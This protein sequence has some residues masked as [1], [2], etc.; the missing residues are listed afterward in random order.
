MNLSQMTGGGSDSYIGEIVTGNPNV[1]G[2]NP[3]IGTK[4]YLQTGML[5]RITGN[6]QFGAVIE[7]QPLLCFKDSYNNNQAWDYNNW[8]LSRSQTRHSSFG[9]FSIGYPKVVRHPNGNYFFWMYMYCGHMYPE[10]GYGDEGRYGTF[11]KW[12]SS[13][14]SGIAGSHSRYV[15]ANGGNEWLVNDFCMFKNYIYYTVRSNST[16]PGGGIGIQFWR[17][18]GGD[19]S[20]TF[21]PV[22]GG[23]WGNGGDYGTFWYDWRQVY[24][25]ASP[26]RLL[27]I[28]YNPFLYGGGLAQNA[29]WSTTDGVNITTHNWNIPTTMSKFTWSPCANAATGQGFVMLGTNNIWYTSSNGNVWTQ[30]TTAGT[31]HQDHSAPLSYCSIAHSNTASVYSFGS[32]DGM[33]NYLYRTTDGNSYS[34]INLANF[35]SLHGIFCRDGVTG[36]SS[37]HTIHF[38]ANTFAIINRLGATATSVDDGLTW[39]LRPSFRHLR[40]IYPRSRSS[41]NG[42]YIFVNPPGNFGE[43]LTNAAIRISPP[44]TVWA[45][46]TNFQPNNIVC[47]NQSAI[48]N[49]SGGSNT[50]N[51]IIIAN[52]IW[53]D[54][55]SQY[56]P[57]E[58]SA[59]AALS[60]NLA[61]NSTADWVGMVEKV[62]ISSNTSYWTSSVTTPFSNRPL[63]TYVRIR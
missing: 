18:S 61:S 24:M 37:V 44:T 1:L 38:N 34:Q 26:D 7:Q 3:I 36:G 48:S 15:W 22:D 49:T 47:F 17:S 55:I 50:G 53:S 28:P 19:F 56:T 2:I 13:L 52:T 54:G 23:N 27:F 42:D 12:G 16:T 11:I 59:N 8:S 6:T 41:A 4:E 46:N 51:T 5:K 29:M 45:G 21:N 32:P 40:H 57:V 10:Y 25:A 43:P 62:S 14:N 33:N 20:N 31:S 58:V 60:G 30:R 39:Q 9:G 35:P 63:E